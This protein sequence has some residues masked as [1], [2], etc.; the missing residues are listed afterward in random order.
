M[1]LYVYSQLVFLQT[2]DFKRLS[3]QGFQEASDLKGL[4]TVFESRPSVWQPLGGGRLWSPVTSR[5]LLFYQAAAPVVTS[6]L[7]ISYLLFLI[8][9]A[10]VV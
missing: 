7:L 8:S 3:F 4:S 2:S 9:D 5:A 10:Q 1:E 6:R